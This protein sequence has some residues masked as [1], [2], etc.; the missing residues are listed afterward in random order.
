M[1][2]NLRMISAWWRSNMTNCRCSHSSMLQPSVTVSVTFG[3]FGNCITLQLYIGYVYRSLKGTYVRLSSPILYQKIYS[4]SERWDM[5][6]KMK[7]ILCTIACSRWVLTEWSTNTFPP[8]LYLYTEVCTMHSELCLEDIIW[9][10]TKFMH[11]ISGRP[12]CTLKEYLL[13]TQSIGFR[14]PP[15]TSSCVECSYTHLVHY[16]SPVGVLSACTHT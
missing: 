6:N 1:C 13:T 14:K 11:R 3:L 5:K 9:V 15:L 4:I 2:R 10:V 12:C 16:H 8:Q 7:Y